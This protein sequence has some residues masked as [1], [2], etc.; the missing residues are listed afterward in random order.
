MSASDWVFKNVFI[1]FLK[2]LERLFF[3]TYLRLVSYL[4][5]T[6]QLLFNYNGFSVILCN[7]QQKSSEDRTSN[8]KSESNFTV[9]LKFT[10]NLN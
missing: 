6:F 9:K 7:R 10:W 4:R 5:I 1:N 8:K 2:S 3:Q